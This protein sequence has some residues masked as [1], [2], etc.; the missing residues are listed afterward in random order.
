MTST[1]GSDCERGGADRLRA[2]LEYIIETAIDLLDDLDAAGEDLEDDELGD[3][4]AL[5]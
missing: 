5:A 3:D 1:G 4:G 2:W